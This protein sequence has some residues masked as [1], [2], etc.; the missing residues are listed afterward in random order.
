MKW[1]KMLNEYNT[2]FLKELNEKATKA[3][4]AKLKKLEKQ[5]RERTSGGNAPLLFNKMDALKNFLQN[6]QI[7]EPRR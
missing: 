6:S 2:L 3:D 5:I 4:I 1:K 7:K